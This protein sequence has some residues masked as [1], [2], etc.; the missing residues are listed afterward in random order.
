MSTIL[1]AL[2]RLEEETPPPSPVAAADSPEAAAT[3]RPQEALRERVIAEEAAVDRSAEAG[4]ASEPPDSPLARIILHAPLALLVVGLASVAAATSWW[5]TR[6]PDDVPPASGAPVIAAREASSPESRSASRSATPARTVAPVPVAAA[7][8]GGSDADPD[9]PSSSPAAG[10][11]TAEPQTT[12]SFAPPPTAVVAVASAEGGGGSSPEV[13]RGGASEGAPASAVPRSAPA[14]VPAAVVADSSS[15]GGSGAGRS[16]SGGRARAVDSSGSA[17]SPAASP[18]VVRSPVRKTNSPSVPHARQ[19]RPKPS[20]PPA[21]K[22][23]P[24]VAAKPAPARASTRTPEVERVDRPG[25]PDVAVV[26]TVWHP[27]RDRRSAEVQVGASGETV[28][29]REGDAVGGMVVREISP[30]SVVF[31]AGAVEVRRRVGQPG[32]R[33]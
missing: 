19:S 30:S 28:K 10:A 25:L 17:R 4:S 18:S 11:S 20:P 14:P 29:L 31:Q 26:K 6:I 24:A 32:S 27:H 5:L 2:R 13:Q 8:S 15:S 23:T 16:A 33:R 12:R 9:S 1:K 22:R 7:T 3:V 21:A